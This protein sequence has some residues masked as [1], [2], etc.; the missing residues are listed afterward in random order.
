MKTNH[1]IKQISIATRLNIIF[2]LVFLV[3]GSVAFVLLLLSSKVKESAQGALEKQVP[4]AL[5]IINML[6][7][8]GKLNSIEYVLDESEEKQE[9]LTNF[10]KLENFQ[11]PIPHRER[12]QL[13]INQ[14]D[15]LIQADKES[16]AK[17]VFNT[18]DTFIDRKAKEK[19][20]RLIINVGL[21][22]EKLL[23][24]RKEEQITD[25]GSKGNFQKVVEEDLPGVGYY[26]EMNAAVG[27]MLAAV[28]RLI[29]EDTNAKKDFFE[30]ALEFELNL[31][32]LK[33]IEEKPE[34]VI[35]LKEIDRLFQELKTEGKE[36]F[37]FNQN[38]Y[39]TAALKTIEEL[40]HG[41]FYLTK[42]LL[43]KLSYIYGK[44]VKESI[45]SL[46]QLV[47]YLNII[48]IFTIKIG[49]GLIVM[50]VVYGRIAILQ[51]VSEITRAVELLRQR[52]EQ[53]EITETKYYYEFDQVIGSLKLFHK[54]LVEA[55]WETKAEKV[56]V[57]E[58]LSKPVSHS[59]LFN[60]IARV[61]G[62]IDSQVTGEKKSKLSN[63]IAAQFED[64]NLLLVEDNQIN[65]EIRKELL[66]GVGSQVSVANNTQEAIAVVQK[67][68]FDEV[69]MDIQ[70]PEMDSMIEFPQLEGIN[71][72]SGI[73]RIGGNQTVYKEI[74][75]QF[76]H[77]SGETLDEIQTA[78]A[79]SDYETA[80]QKA[81]S[82]KGV[83]G[84][85]GA[86]DLYQVAMSLEMA[87]KQEK[88]QVI[89]PL[90]DT[91]S[92]QFQKVMNS[93]FKLDAPENN[94]EDREY[95]KTVVK[96]LDKIV[97][98]DRLEKLGKLLNSD[99]GKALDL[100]A[101]METIFIGTYYW[102]K[103]QKLQ[104]YV[105]EF[106]TDAAFSQLEEIERQIK[107]F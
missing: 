18:Y 80:S 54:E 53:F 86:D 11:T 81:H 100:V 28:T 19:I 16:S 37:S 52:K 1:Q 95:G 92:Q 40:E 50:L 13:E 4:T 42:S 7:E 90:M 107:N 87:L 74:L 63:R 49:I 89:S 45:K 24:E 72:A 8:L 85:I 35:K 64:M 84:N 44:E 26:L 41:N 102:W 57:D 88:T 5:N 103:F 46:N 58:L 20:K 14:L 99:I 55:E 43:E 75:Q 15:T 10:S 34:E 23:I 9:F 2:A 106:E 69:L 96:E 62:K 70:M 12:Y 76:R 83:A 17:L 39:R 73:N 65:Q 101:E 67:R 97:L 61:F 82:I 93:I 36:I 48:T 77:D 33:L 60:A 31:A 78:V 29:L 25:A 21:P 38:E 27:D 51:P 59:V 6:E 94:L 104:E 79:A 47:I 22:L 68:D 71:V 98:G 66:E 3:I 30:Q 91:F 32:K 56:G 105:N